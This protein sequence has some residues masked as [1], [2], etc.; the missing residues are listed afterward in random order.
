MHQKSH[1]NKS[2]GGQTDITDFC[3]QLTTRCY[4]FYPRHT[5]FTDSELA[6]IVKQQMNKLGFQRHWPELLLGRGPSP[7]IHSLL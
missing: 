2:Q 7:S 5:N 6:Q 1:R 4:Q 3:S